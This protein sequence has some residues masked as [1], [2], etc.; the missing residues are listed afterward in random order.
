MTI[1][2]SVIRDEDLAC[3]IELTTSY[4]LTTV[5]VLSSC[6]RS[7]PGQIMKFIYGGNFYKPCHPRNHENLNVY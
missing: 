2:H 7:V 3:P 4:I 1:I 6:V 5:A